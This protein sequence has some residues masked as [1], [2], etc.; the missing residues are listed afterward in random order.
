MGEQLE[1]DA[2]EVPAE[3]ADGLV[4]CLAFGAFS[5]VGALRLRDQFAVVI[6]GGRHRRLGTGVDMPGRL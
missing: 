3:G 2:A 6:D 5:L 1:D 4:V